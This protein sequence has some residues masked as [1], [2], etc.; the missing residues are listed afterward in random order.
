MK[1][2]SR[3]LNLLNLDLFSPEAKL[4]IGGKD[5]AKTK[6]GTAISLLYIPTLVYLMYIIISDYFDTRRPKVSQAIVPTDYPPIMS[7]TEDKLFPM[8]VF[9]YKVTSALK[10]PE[11]DKFVTMQFG[12]LSINKDPATGQSKSSFQLMKTASCGDLIAQGKMR[13]IVF[14]SQAE[15]DYILDGGICVDPESADIVIGRNSEKDAY[16]QRVAWRVMPCSLPSGCAPKEELAKVTFAPL[17]PRA[18]QDLGNKKEP[19]RYSSSTEEMQYLSSAFTLRQNINLLKSEIIDEAGFLFGDKL[20]KS[21]TTISSVGFGSSDRPSNMLSCTQ[22]QVDELT[23]V[24]YF[25]QSFMG[26]PQKM[27]IKRQYKGLVET[28]SEIG[29]MADMLFTQSSCCST[30]STAEE[31]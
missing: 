8:M 13:S 26:G 30:A 29:G 15:K 18:I 10:K 24:P 14:S 23:C 16:F 5:G 11:L 20:V 27:I 25:I 17:V 21:F 6:V 28:F 2:S 12:L 3:K 1:K 4:N 9:R 19:V 7:F 22:Q 31:F